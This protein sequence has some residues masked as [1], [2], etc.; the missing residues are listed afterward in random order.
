VATS[1]IPAHMRQDHQ[2]P[3]RFRPTAQTS[4]APVAVPLGQQ[5]GEVTLP[6]GGYPDYQ[7]AGLRYAAGQRTQARNTENRGALTTGPGDPSTPTMYPTDYGTAS[8]GSPAGAS[9]TAQSTNA[10]GTAAAGAAADTKAAKKKHKKKKKDAKKAAG[11][12][13]RLGLGR[14]GRF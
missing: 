14:T 6:E 1:N 10:P 8:S 4:K 11:L 12:A 3:P 7:E 13:A 5:L 2:Q 9:S